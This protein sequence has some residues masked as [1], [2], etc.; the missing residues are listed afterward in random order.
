MVP[1]SSDMIFFSQ[2]PEITGGKLLQLRSDS[3]IE[4]LSIDSRKAAAQEGTLFFAIRGE[5]HDGHQYISD[6]Y[7]MGTRQFVIE[8]PTQHLNDFPEANFVLVSSTVSALQRVAAFHRK[9]FSI[10]VIGITGSNGKTII[11]EWLYQILSKDQIVVKNPGS[12]NSQVGVPLSVWQIKPH[13]QI[14]IFEA[15]I[16]RPGEMERLESVIHPTIGILTNIGT[17][18]DEGFR[19]QE[20]KIEEKLKLFKNSQVLIY[21]ADHTHVKRVIQKIGVRTYSWGRDQ[22]ADLLVSFQ[23]HAC[24]ISHAGQ[25]HT[26]E[27][28]FADKAS[29]ENC[30]HCVALLIYLGFNYKKVQKSINSLRSVPMRMEMKEG[31][32]QSY[33]IDDTYNNDLGGLELSLQFLT[34]QNQKRKK[35]LILSDILE[36][37]LP[38][39][40]LAKQILV[41]L[42]KYPVQNFVGI[43]HMLTSEQR[44]FPE[45]SLFYPTTQAF[46]DNFD[47]GSVHEEVILVK[48]ARTFAFE[49]I[50]NRLQRKLHGTVMEVD[51][52]SLVH[53]LNVFRSLLKPETKIMVM[54]K[55]FAYGSGSPEVA[56]VLQYH[57]VDYL[58]VAYVDEGVDLRKNNI[59]IPI[60][61]MNPSEDSFDSLINYN[62][63]PEIYSFRIFHSLIKYLGG[64]P[65][66][67]HL[68][69]DTGMHRLGFAKEELSDLIQLLGQNRNITVASIFTHLAAADESDQ[70][71]FSNHQA[72]VF[73]EAADSISTFLGY[74]PLY[75]ILNSSGILRL[76]HLQF[77]MV[78]LG[79]GLY[80]VDPSHPDSRELSPVAALKTVISQIKSIKKGET[81]GYGRKGIARNDLRVATIAIG[82]ADGF[83]RRLSQGVG[84]V[85]IAGKRAR[86]IGNVCMDMTMVDVTEIDAKEGD[87]V[88]IFGAE[89]PIQEIASKIQTIPYELLTSIS[90]RVK[91]IFVSDGI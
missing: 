51:L 52:S 78:R 37:G 24:H 33:L 91:R 6:L 60:M 7:R 71:E 18:H 13:H 26:L 81:V 15:G 4:Y 12:Y 73:K 23:H 39:E 43:G 34:H 63:E 55:A 68:K 11:K 72:A 46:L 44:L 20:E 22:G 49:K 19:D 90:E 2:L 88:V 65:C 83:S 36:S 38:A 79:I 31:I 1:G 66:F 50:A 61:V 25:T 64:R 85:I 32:N 69:L 58:G 30:L 35:R 74:R 29:I 59:V 45:N 9:R 28:P 17:A 77:D 76:P 75:H 86:V 42:E 89:L 62:L 5:R 56:N 41:L 14:G 27:M 80:G 47:F 8:Q 16:S 53:N 3:Q 82:Y 84:E 57:K 21:C 40:L 10:P 70:D 67:V 48:G 87:E 54:V